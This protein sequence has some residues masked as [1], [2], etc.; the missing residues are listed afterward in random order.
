[1]AEVLNLGGGGGAGME[2]DDRLR[3]IVYVLRIDPFIFFNLII[4]Y[5][6]P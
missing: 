4:K 3:C 5:K 1:M 6:F 2:A